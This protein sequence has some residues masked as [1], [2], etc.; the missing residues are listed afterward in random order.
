MGQLTIVY[1]RDIPSQVIAKSGRA[2]EKRMLPDR[3]QEAIDL[4]A[5]RDGA[6]GT[7]AYL[8]DWRRT[9]P[10]DCGEDLAGEAERAASTLEASFDKD[11]LNALIGNGGR[12]PA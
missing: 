12:E 8:A 7:D 3:F 10:V 11:R 9:D 6:S 4:A 2:N 1:W 5:M